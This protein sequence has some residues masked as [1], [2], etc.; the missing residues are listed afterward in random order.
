VITLIPS[1]EAS[2]LFRFRQNQY[3]SEETISPCAR[4]PRAHTTGLLVD[5]LRNRTDPSANAM[6]PPPGWKL[7]SPYMPG[8]SQSPSQAHMRQ[9]G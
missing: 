1:T 3:V 8:Q 4:D 5:D 6:L 7:L 2:S 9:L